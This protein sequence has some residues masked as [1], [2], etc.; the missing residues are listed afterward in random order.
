[1]AQ[2]NAERLTPAHRQSDE[3][4]VIAIGHLTLN[5]PG[6]A[7]WAAASGVAAQRRLGARRPAPHV[8]DC[9]RKLRRVITPGDFRES[10]ANVYAIIRN[11]RRRNEKLL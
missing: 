11:A 2:A 7:N 9:A 8:A 5:S 1:L 6:G 10:A 4:A 3:R